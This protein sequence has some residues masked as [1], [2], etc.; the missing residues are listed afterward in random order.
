MSSEY[1]Y[2]N[3]GQQNI[4]VDEVMTSLFFMSDTEW[5]SAKDKGE[6]DYVV[7]GSSFCAL[8]FTHQ[9]L[10]NKSDAKILI[11]DRGSYFHPEHF[12]NLPPAFSKT[13]EGRSET[14][15]WK[16][17]EKTHNGEYIKYQ[18]G[19]NNFFGGR[20]SFW[21]SWC[22]EPTDEEM[23]NWPKEVIETVHRYFAA[24]K[25]LINVV[26]SN[27]ISSSER[28][29]KIFGRLQEAVFNALE[30]APSKNEAITRVIYAPLAV[31]ADMYRYA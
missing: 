31:K 25:E 22:P 2:P 24:A 18:H 26:P 28:G 3:P 14:F 8:A 12:Q 6:F 30:S 29:C 15:H 16:L 20:S 10:K 9:V 19:M 13:V 21:S 7:I 27:E 23:V 17:T 4:S 11:V 1:G 5:E